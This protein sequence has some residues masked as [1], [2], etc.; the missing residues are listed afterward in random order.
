M[1]RSHHGRGGGGWTA[2]A[3]VPAAKGARAAV[4]ALAAATLAVVAPTVTAQGTL[5]VVLECP[6]SGLRLLEVRLRQG[7]GLAPA[8]GLRGRRSLDRAGP[9]LRSLSE[10]R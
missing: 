8:W 9:R 6:S 10:L 1:R 5:D 7:A 4:L 3:P 2:A